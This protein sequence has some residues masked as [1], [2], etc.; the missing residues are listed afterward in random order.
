MNHKV[1]RVR[2]GEPPHNVFHKAGSLGQTR[3]TG[4]MVPMHAGTAWRLSMNLTKA[5]LTQSR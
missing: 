5:F 2:P 1:G 4:F 3:P